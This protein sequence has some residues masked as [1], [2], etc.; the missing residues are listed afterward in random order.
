M[1]FYA[2]LA[3]YFIMWMSAIA[4]VCGVLYVLVEAWGWI[5]WLLKAE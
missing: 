5:K 4:V 3:I 1:S 2:V